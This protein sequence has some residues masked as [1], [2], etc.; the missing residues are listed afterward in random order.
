MKGEIH[1]IT[2]PG[3]A[4]GDCKFFEGSSSEKV[5]IEFVAF[6]PQPGTPSFMLSYTLHIRRGISGSDAYT[7]TSSTERGESGSFDRERTIG[8]LL[9]HEDKCSFAVTLDVRAKIHNGFTRLRSLD[10]HDIAA[11][12][13]EK[14]TSSS[15]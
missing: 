5:A 10:A 11:F 4:A 8:A 7:E 9:D 15:S 12:A 13:A 2:G 14:D 1:D 6:H 3:A